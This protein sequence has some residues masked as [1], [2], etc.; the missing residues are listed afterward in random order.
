MDMPDHMF[1]FHTVLPYLKQVALGRPAELQ[2]AHS[3]GVVH[4]WEDGHGKRP[5]QIP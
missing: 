4:L 2:V 3:S 1:K 5:V